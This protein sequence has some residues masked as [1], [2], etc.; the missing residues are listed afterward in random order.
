MAIILEQW[1]EVVSQLEAIQENYNERVV[2]N[3]PFCEKLIS[4]N[5]ELQ[6]A[7]NKAEDMG[8]LL[9][10]DIGSPAIEL[11]DGMSI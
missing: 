3:Q 7:I 6:L 5:F 9:Q 2:D 4:A 10:D 1:N 8:R 11:L